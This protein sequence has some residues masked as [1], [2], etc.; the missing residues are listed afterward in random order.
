MFVEE[1]EAGFLKKRLPREKVAE[2]MKP[3]SN[4][5]F[6]CFLLLSD[7]KMENENNIFYHNFNVIRL[8]KRIFSFAWLLPQT[9]PPSARQLLPHCDGQRVILEV[10]S[11]KLYLAIW[12]IHNDCALLSF[13]SCADPNDYDN[14]NFGPFW[15]YGP[16]IS[17]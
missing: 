2:L 14:L 10:S 13:S 15:S 8:K 5:Q 6:I 16:R 7:P 12:K 4:K 3:W 9:H 1:L 11:T 17:K